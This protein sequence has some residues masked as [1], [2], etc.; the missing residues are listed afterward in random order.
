M[1]MMEIVKRF[2]AVL[3]SIEKAKG[4]RHVTGQRMIGTWEN[5]VNVVIENVMSKRMIRCGTSI[6]SW[7]DELR[8][9][10]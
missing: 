8:G 10:L 1:E 9:A 4:K 6:K 7:D 5:V 2:E 3:K